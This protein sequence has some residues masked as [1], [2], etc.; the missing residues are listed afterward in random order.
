MKPATLLDQIS[1]MRKHPGVACLGFALGGFI[2]IATYVVAHFETPARPE[3][4]LVVAGGLVFSPLTVWEQAR[5]W[6]ASPYKAS[7][8]VLVLEGVMVSSATLAL[9]VAA[10]SILATVNGLSVGYALI[11]QSRVHATRSKAGKR[12]AATRRRKRPAGGPVVRKGETLEY[13]A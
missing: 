8:F 1:R 7:G 13:H 12:A 3:M 5:Y 10:L 4:W 11:G 9:S 2:P 6:F